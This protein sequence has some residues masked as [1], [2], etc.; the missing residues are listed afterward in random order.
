VRTLPEDVDQAG[1]FYYVLELINYFVLLKVG[2]ET[3][4]ENTENT[5]LFI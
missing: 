4:T 1:Y 3:H 5:N 2:A